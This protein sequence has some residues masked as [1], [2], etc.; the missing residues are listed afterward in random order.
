MVCCDP[1]SRLGK[2]RKISLDA[3]EK[4]LESSNRLTDSLDSGTKFDD[5]SELHKETSIDAT[6]QE[7]TAQDFMNALKTISN[8]EI[9]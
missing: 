1:K 6:A 2:L 8:E 5:I 3:H 4:F 7:S 9:L